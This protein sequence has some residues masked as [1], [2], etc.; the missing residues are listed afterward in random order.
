MAATTALPARKKLSPRRLAQRVR[1]GQY[2]A[3][4]LLVL[5]AVLFI[6]GRQVASTFFRSDM[7]R[8]TVTGQLPLAFGNTIAYTAGAF[9]VGLLA[10]VRHGAVVQDGIRGDHRSVRPRCL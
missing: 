3:L 4:G 6:D 2:A 9:V 1:I 10:D 8:K 7:I 5:L